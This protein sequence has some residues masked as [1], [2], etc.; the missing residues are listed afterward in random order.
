MTSSA[1]KVYHKSVRYRMHEIEINAYRPTKPGISFCTENYDPVNHEITYHYSC[2][3]DPTLQPE[4]RRTIDDIEE[5]ISRL[6]SRIVTESKIKYPN[7][8]YQEVRSILD[9]PAY[10]GQYDSHRSR[11][12][13]VVSK[14]ITKS[15]FY[16]INRY[17]EKLGIKGLRNLN[18]EM[19]LMTY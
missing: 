14:T 16:D 4:Q 18:V 5:E 11:A 1:A 17:Y 2:T 10:D 7:P 13:D 3:D 12:K 15:A 8:F 6:S 9:L 19:G